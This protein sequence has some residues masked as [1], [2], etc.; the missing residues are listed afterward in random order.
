MSLLQAIGQAQA[1]FITNENIQ[2]AFDSLLKNLLRLTQS[3]QG[4]I[5]EI[6][7]EQEQGSD[8]CKPYLKVRAMTSDATDSTNDFMFNGDLEFRD[9]DSLIGR[10]FSTL[11]PV[12][13]NNP[14]SDSSGT[15]IPG[16]HLNMN[17][18]LGIPIRHDN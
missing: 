10:A 7:Y 1:A 6:L 16:D 17:A 8:E 14:A 3:Q 15:N 4:F 2:Q 12:I 5:G 9:P 18:F 13:S 11:Y